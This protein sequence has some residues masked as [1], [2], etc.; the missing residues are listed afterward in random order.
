MHR[1]KT[2][3]LIL[4]G[5]VVSAV[6]GCVAV[7]PRPAH[8]PPTEL[9]RLSRDV[10]PQV[11]QAPAREA[12]DAALPPSPTPPGGGAE[13]EAPRRAVVARPAPAPPRQAPTGP[14]APPRAAD[15]PPRV[16]PA[17]PVP[18]PTGAA[19]GLGTGVCA[20]GEG[21]GGWRPGSPQARIC[22]ETYGH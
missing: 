19:A 16:L 6:S 5:V 10:Q 21:Y 20:L 11:V 18:V 13:H 14:A 4:M 2:S 3:A 1:T 9:P 17:L 22:R 7:Q 15:R 8:T 12:L